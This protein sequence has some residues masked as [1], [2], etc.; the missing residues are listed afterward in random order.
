MV[1]ITNYGGQCLPL[2]LASKPHSPLFG[3]M[4]K[5]NSIKFTFLAYLQ[6]N[7]PPLI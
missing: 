5:E 6:L 1:N 3:S 4:E 7:L 2:L